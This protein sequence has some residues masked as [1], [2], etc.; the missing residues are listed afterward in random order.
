MPRRARKADAPAPPALAP[1]PACGLRLGPGDTPSGRALH[2]CREVQTLR[3]L[4]DKERAE[5]SLEVELEAYI[6]RQME[7]DTLLPKDAA[8]VLVALRRGRADT[9]AGPSEALLAFLRE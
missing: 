2:D 4:A 6:R 8:S 1:C 5:T 7:G 3:K 9:S